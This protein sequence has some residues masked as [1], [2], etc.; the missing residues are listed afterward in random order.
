MGDITGYVLGTLK[1]HALPQDSSIENVS[2]F[3][4]YHRPPPGLYYTTITLEEL[5]GLRL[6]MRFC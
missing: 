3:V 1:L 6:L 4:R 2:R 5:S